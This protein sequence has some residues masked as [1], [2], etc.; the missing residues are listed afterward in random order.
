[1]T[2]IKVNIDSTDHYLE[3]YENDPINLVFQYSDIEKIQSAVGSF[4]QTFR[5]PATEVN[6]AAFGDFTNPNN[7]G[8]NAKRKSSAIIMKDTLPLIS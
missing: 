5:I 1:M 7:I 3:L 4:S 6:F 8:F 2:T